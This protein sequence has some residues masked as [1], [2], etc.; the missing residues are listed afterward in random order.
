MPEKKTKWQSRAA[1]VAAVCL[2][3]AVG[4]R[5]GA[6]AADNSDSVPE[7]QTPVGLP[8]SN[9]H[10]GNDLALWGASNDE[11]VVRL[12]TEVE[13]FQDLVETNPGE[14]YEEALDRTQQDLEAVCA[15]PDTT[16]C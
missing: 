3:V 5:V 12:Q 4:F 11:W 1:A 15:L 16:V 6:G 7:P 10:A 8:S 2:I 9:V 14:G 13:R